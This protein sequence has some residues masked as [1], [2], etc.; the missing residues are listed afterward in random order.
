MRSVGVN[1]N[2]IPHPAFR[3]EL[4][5]L[6]CRVPV[7]VYKKAAVSLRDVLDEKIYDERRFADAR[8]ALDVDVLRGVDREILS[9]DVV[10]ANKGIHLREQ[11]ESNLPNRIWSPV[12]HLGSFAPV[13]SI[14]PAVI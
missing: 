2:E 4:G 12:R 8:H 10:L 3:N 11:Q 9:C 13:Q 1:P 5:Y 7:R 6:V 14:V